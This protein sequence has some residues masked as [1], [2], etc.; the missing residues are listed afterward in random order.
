MFFDKLPLFREICSPVG[1]LAT[2]VAFILDRLMVRLIVAA[3]ASS[4]C[5][6]GLRHQGNV[7][8]KIQ[9]CEIFGRTSRSLSWS[10]GNSKLEIA[11]SLS[12]KVVKDDYKQK[13]S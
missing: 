2:I 10:Q 13:W 4:F 9:I 11:Q 6:G 5:T 12:K 7:L 1:Q 3:A 8:S